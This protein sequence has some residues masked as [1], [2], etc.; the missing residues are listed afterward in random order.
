MTDQIRPDSP[1]RTLQMH[2]DMAD[3]LNSFVGCDLG[4]K[5]FKKNHDQVGLIVV[6]FLPI[7]RVE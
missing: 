4:W 1:I 5:G 2:A 3:D 7:S 6:P